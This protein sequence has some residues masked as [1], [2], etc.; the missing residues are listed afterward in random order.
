MRVEVEV[1][2][3]RQKRGRGREGERGGRGREGGGGG[4]EGGEE[5]GRGRVWVETGRHVI[6]FVAHVQDV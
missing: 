4:V 1:G 5:G 3:G 2:G 6:S